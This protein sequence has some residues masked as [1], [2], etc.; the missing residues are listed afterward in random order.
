MGLAP[1]RAATGEDEGEG[2]RAEEGEGRRAAEGEG[3]ETE[4]RG[5]GRRGRVEVGEDNVID[6][7]EREM[8]TTLMLLLLLLLLLFLDADAAT[9]RC[10]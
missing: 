1:A 3:E 6:E 2:R 10:C 7:V 4:R 8:L 9:E 5:G